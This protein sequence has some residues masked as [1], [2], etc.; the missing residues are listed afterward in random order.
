MP[1]H[2]VALNAV[3][4]TGT[5]TL[6]LLSPVRDNVLSTSGAS[7]FSIPAGMKVIAAWLGSTTILRGRLV[8]P[9]LLRVG[10]PYIRP[11]TLGTVPG[12]DPNFQVL[13][14]NPLTINDNE[15]LGVEA[16]HGAVGNETVRALIWLCDTLEAPPAG[17][18]FWVRYV[19]TTAAV[20]DAWTGLA[21]TM[22][23]LPVGNYAVVGFEHWSANCIG[24]RLVFPG[25]VLRPG[26]AGLSGGSAPSAAR[27]HAAFYEGKL[28]VYGTFQA[29]TLP[30][31][32]VL[33]T[34]TDAVHEGYLRLVRL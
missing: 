2:T 24:A 25:K 22:D 10:Y 7:G 21:L 31:V 34:S 26:T 4:P 28:G 19:S 16:M 15:V 5:T 17:S 1:V 12:T 18:T 27:T 11:N 33:S 9:S 23:Q 30:G 13:F 8:A 32:E 20:A 14:D 29:F 6:T 3:V